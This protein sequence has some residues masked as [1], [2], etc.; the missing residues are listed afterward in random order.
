MTLSWAPGFCD[1]G[2]KETSSPECAEGSGDGFVVHGLWPNNEYR[3]NPEFCLGHDAS[4]ADLEDEHGVYPNDRLAAYEYRKHGTCT[5]LSPHDYFATV[6]SVR[7]RLKIPQMLQAT[8]EPL[9]M[10]PEE[11]EQAFMTAN[12]NLHPDNMAISCSNGELVDVR[13]LPGEGSLV[14]RR[15]PQGRAAHLPTRI[16]H[17][18]ASALTGLDAENFRAEIDA[19]FPLNYRHAFHAGNFADVLKHAVLARVLVY[20]PARK[21]LSLHRHPRRGGPVRSGEPRGEALA[22]M[23]R[24]DRAR[25]DG[26]RRPRRSR[27]SCAPICKPSARTTRRA[28]RCPIRARRRSRKPSCARRIASRSAKR[29]RTNARR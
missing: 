7:G 22:G 21:P 14:L 15:L 18:R 11:I 8:S 19:G 28:G 10:S 16:D 17:G 6:G 3:P 20:L 29:T 13:L 26:A 5:G 1:L 4:P 12:P 27:S 24:R 23:A 25:S 2:G 9:H